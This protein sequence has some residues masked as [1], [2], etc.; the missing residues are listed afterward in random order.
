MKRSKQIF[1]IQLSYYQQDDGHIMFNGVRIRSQIVD[2]LRL[3]N[4][5]QNNVFM[6]KKFIFT[7]MLELFDV[8]NMIENQLEPLK[9]S[10]V[11][12]E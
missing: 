2:I 6:D 4:Q 10:V 9:R 5:L 11:H 3:Q 12:G 1:F 7:L 8:E